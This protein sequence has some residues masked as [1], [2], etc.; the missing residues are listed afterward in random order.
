MGDR[1]IAR[2]LVQPL[3]GEEFA[4]HATLELAAATG[5]AR[6]TP[7]SSMLGEGRML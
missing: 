5:W 1:A 3:R 4:G 6:D 2:P 7:G